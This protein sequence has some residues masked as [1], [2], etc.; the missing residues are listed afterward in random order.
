MNPVFPWDDKIFTGPLGQK[1]T[2]YRNLRH[3]HLPVDRWKC[4]PPLQVESALGKILPGIFLGEWQFVCS[5]SVD[6]M[7]SLAE[8]TP[9]IFSLTTCDSANMI[10][11][12]RVVQRLRMRDAEGLAKVDDLL[13]QIRN[14][15]FL[16]WFNISQ[17]SESRDYY[18]SRFADLLIK[19]KS[20]S[21]PILFFA[22]YV[23]DKPGAFSEDSVLSIINQVT[24][25]IGE[26][27]ALLIKEKSSFVY[28]EADIPPMNISGIRG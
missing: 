3:M 16:S 18:H 19:R 12:D 22:T 15:G 5:N 21:Y 28:I 17:S 23:A 7:L 20:L 9:I 8:L 24:V 26:T 11:T 25:A 10:T 14:F 2:V 27:A 13:W 4:P 1:E 6:L